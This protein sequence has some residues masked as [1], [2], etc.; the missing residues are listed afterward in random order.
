MAYYGGG[1]GVSGIIN[2]EFEQDRISYGQYGYGLYE[3]D[4]DYERNP[5]TG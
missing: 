2:Q 5:F 4:R 1:Y 3:T